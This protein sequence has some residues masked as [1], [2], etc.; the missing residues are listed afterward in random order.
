MFWS[1]CIPMYSLGL[2][3][4][5]DG[6][7]VRSCRAWVLLGNKAFL[8]AIRYSWLAGVSH[9]GLVRALSTSLRVWSL[10]LSIFFSYSGGKYRI[11]R[12]YWI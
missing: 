8:P 9:V 11:G 2:S 5:S 4:S 12:D 6:A 3:V 1:H 7:G 10:F